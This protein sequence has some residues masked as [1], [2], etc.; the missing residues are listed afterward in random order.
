M[1]PAYR[2]GGKSCVEKDCGGFLTAFG[3]KFGAYSVSKR[4]FYFHPIFLQ[5]R[6]GY[7]LVVI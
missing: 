4:K 2:R 7:L 1:R 5:I 6:S 3:A